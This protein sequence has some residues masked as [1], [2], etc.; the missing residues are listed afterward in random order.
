MIKNYAMRAL[1]ENNLVLQKFMHAM[2]GLTGHD[3]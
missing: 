2:S 3:T 1:M